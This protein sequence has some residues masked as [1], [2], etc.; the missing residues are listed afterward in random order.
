MVAVFLATAVWRNADLY[1]VARQDADAKKTAAELLGTDP[2]D[3]FDGVEHYLPVFAAESP[4]PRLDLT[5]SM[6]THHD[7]EVTRWNLPTCSPSKFED[8]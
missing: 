5:E 2:N 3:S 1:N 8:A 4:R 6:Q 7:L